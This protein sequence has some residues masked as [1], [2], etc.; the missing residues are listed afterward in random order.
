M[1][2]RSR[3]ACA[4]SRERATASCSAPKAPV[5]RSGCTTSSPAKDSMPPQPNPRPARCDSSSHRSTAASS[6][7]APSSRWLPKPISP[8]VDACTGAARGARKGQDYYDALEP[9]DYVV[10]YQHGVGRYLEMK[11]L[12]MAGTERDYL[13]LEFKDGKVYVPTDQVGL[14]RKYTGGETPSLNRMGG[15]DF[16]RQRAKVRE[17]GPRDRRRTGGALPPAHRH[18][19]P[20]VRARHALAA[21]GG[22]GVPVRGDARSAAGHQRREGRHGAADPDGPSR[23]RRRRLRQDRGGGARRVQGRAGRYA[24][25]RARTDH[26]ARRPTRPDVPR[27]VRQLSG[28]GRGAVAVPVEQGTGGR[29]A[30]LRVGRGRH[31]DR[32]APPALGRRAA[33]RTSGSSSSTRSSASACST[34]S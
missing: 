5:R 8:A 34:R 3:V 29:R 9:G 32:Y 31:P 23:L 30:R 16:E 19:G 33:R 15:A 25:R 22:G 27:T 12:T 26:P 11:P 20:R 14:V 7:R 28:A 10:H 6:S 4:R 24:G 17:R 1:P 18:A 21:R 13:W 2:T